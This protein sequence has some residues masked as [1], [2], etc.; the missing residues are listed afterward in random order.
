MY[1]RIDQAGHQGLPSQIHDLCIPPRILAQALT[2][3]LDLLILYYYCCIGNGV[4]AVSVNQ[5]SILKNH[6]LS[7]L[8]FPPI[9]PPIGFRVFNTQYRLKSQRI[10]VPARIGT[11][12]HHTAFR[13]NGNALSATHFYGPV[14]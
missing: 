13:I 2:N 8:M 1:M 12:H 6:Y 5:E 7:H 14:S 9:L 10:A 4:T 11:G 3:V